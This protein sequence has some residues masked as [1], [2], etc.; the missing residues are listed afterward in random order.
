MYGLY[1]AHLQGLLYQA[2]GSIGHVAINF[3][4]IM[5]IQPLNRKRPYFAGG[6]C[7]SGCQSWAEEEVS[8]QIDRGTTC[9]SESS[10]SLL[11]LS[12]HP[13]PTPPFSPSPHTSSGLYHNNTMFV[14]SWSTH[15]HGCICIQTLTSVKRRTVSR[16]QDVALMWMEYRHELS[17][18]AMR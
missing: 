12:P 16:N 6:S 15:V 1:I 18:R 13:S 8:G 2:K 9:S 14:D 10:L 11:P 5:Y 3:D 4:A 17:R 7:A